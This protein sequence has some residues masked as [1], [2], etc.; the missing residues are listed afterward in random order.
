MARREQTPF[1]VWTTVTVAAR[2]GRNTRTKTSRGR[3]VTVQAVDFD[4]AMRVAERELAQDMA[5]RFPPR[6][7]K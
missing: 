6:G 3:A 7:K 2:E 5:G 4:S 1:R